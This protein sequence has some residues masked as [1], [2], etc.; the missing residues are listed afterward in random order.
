MR[1]RLTT[2]LA[3]AG[4]AVLGLAT[5]GLAT[6][7]RLPQPTGLDHVR[8]VAHW[9]PGAGGS[10]AE[11]MA[12]LDHGRMV[13]S[14]NRWGVQDPKTGAW[15]DNH[16]RLFTVR[17][18][19]T[20]AKLGPR[21]DLGGCAMLTG[22]TA[23]HH[24]AYQVIDNFGPDPSCKS[25]SPPSGVYRVTAKGIHLVMQLPEGSFPN[26]ITTHLGKL[27]VTD[28]ANGVVWRG[29]IRHVSKPTKPWLT[30]DLLR[31]TKDVPLGADG[32]AFRHNVVFVTSYGQG[33]VLRAR[34][35]ADGSATK[36]WAWATSKKLVGA[37]GVV[38]DAAG[39]LWVTSNAT[40]DRIIMIRHGGVVVVARTPT[41]ALDYPTQPLVGRGGALYVLNGSYNNGTPSLVLLTR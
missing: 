25:Y 2:V 36:G 10:F 11:S 3:L 8:A 17:R 37:D 19:G 41:R 35:R 39:R 7:D 5:P 18:D 21:L 34:M 1:N 16:G 28:S 31:P 15:G 20:K 32:I 26:G 13:V 4:L 23:W 22:V 12:R 29:A 30:S 24:H 9:A 6:P 27:Y 40:S 14:V 33:L 38:L